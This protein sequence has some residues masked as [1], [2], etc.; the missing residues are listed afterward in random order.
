MSSFHKNPF[1][2]YC[3]MNPYDINYRDLRDRELFGL[4]VAEAG[5]L[6]YAHALEVAAGNFDEALAEIAIELWWC[7]HVCR[8]RKSRSATWGS[9]RGCAGLYASDRY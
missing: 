9:I 4:V 1:N 3:N 8:K 2:G 7:C 6:P 5:A